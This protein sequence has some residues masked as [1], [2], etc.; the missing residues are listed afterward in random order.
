MTPILLILIH[1]FQP[2]H[3]SKQVWVNWMEQLILQLGISKNKSVL[4]T[5]CIPVLTAYSFSHWHCTLCSSLPFQI[6]LSPSLVLE[7]QARWKIIKRSGWEKKDSNIH[8]NQTAFT[9][10]LTIQQ[11]ACRAIYLAKV[12]DL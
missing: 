8:N 12:K 11:L 4:A 6:L 7:L 1:L 9:D 3:A 5:F 2:P 10:C